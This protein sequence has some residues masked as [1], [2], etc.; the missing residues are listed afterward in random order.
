[1]YIVINIALF[2]FSEKPRKHDKKF[3]GPIQNRYVG[4]CKL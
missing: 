3:K 1:M 2:L 4:I